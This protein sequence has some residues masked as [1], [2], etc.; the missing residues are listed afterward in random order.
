VTQAVPVCLRPRPALQADEQSQVLLQALQADVVDKV[1]S[2]ALRTD[3]P[4]GAVQTDARPGLDNVIEFPEFL[5]VEGLSSLPATEGFEA[6]PAESGF[7]DAGPVRP[8]YGP[9]GG[10]PSTDPGREGPGLGIEDGPA[11][12]IFRFR[13]Q[14]V[15]RDGDGDRPSV[16]VPSAQEGTAEADGG[17]V[18]VSEAVV[19]AAQ[20][21]LADECAEGAGE[22]SGPGREL[23]GGEDALAGREG[24]GVS[25]EPDVGGFDKEPE[26]RHRAPSVRARVA[27]ETIV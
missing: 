11:P 22:G 16:G 5:T 13:R 24:S 3:D 26:V 25:E 9:F 12:F 7:Q 23:A 2:P 17:G 1:E 27:G 6:H 20:E 19:T 10:G 8:K 18:G 4:A 14:E 21:V 15:G